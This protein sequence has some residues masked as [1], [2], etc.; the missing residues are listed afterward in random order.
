MKK[1]IFM[2]SVCF[3]LAAT[4]AYAQKKV[5][6][7]KCGQVDIACK[8]NQA[9]DERHMVYGLYK[10]GVEILPIDY[11]MV[12]EENIQLAAF[13]K[14]DEIMLYDFNGRLIDYARLD[15][16]LDHRSF[17]AFER[18]D[19]R[20]NQTYYELMVYF[21]DN[22]WAFESLGTYY[23][24]GNRLYRVDTKRTFIQLN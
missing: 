10:D 22:D 3:M 9:D 14:G 24:K 7:T 2:L 6:H 8:E 16:P 23:R 1:I 15:F 4:G 13:Y 21:S 5:Q 19:A 12:L 17:V 20:R 18:I 11:E